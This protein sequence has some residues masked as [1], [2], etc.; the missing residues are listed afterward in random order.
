MEQQFEDTSES[1]EQSEGFA[2]EDLFEADDAPQAPA[3]VRIRLNGKT[4]EVPEDVAD[5]IQAREAD[6][7]RQISKMGQE[8]G[9]YRRQ[10]EPEPK[11]EVSPQDE[12]MEFFTSPSQAVAKRLK[13]AEERAYRR[14]QEDLQREKSRER[15]WG[16]FYSDNS[17]LKDHQD[18]VEF[19]V[20]KNYEDLKDLDQAN[21]HKEIASRVNQFLGRKPA[22]TTRSLN[23][24]QVVTERSSQPAPQGRR[25]SAP[26]AS[27]PQGRPKLVGISA[28]LAA[29]AEKRRKA[30]YNIKD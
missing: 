23:D 30:Q 9:S 6:Y 17:D 19:V 18:V 3:L 20:Q 24:R 7:Q 11:P 1:L 28:A 14:L 4:I 27:Q 26:E 21:A 22:T 25:Q 13:E 10:S 2:P 12:D 8:L 16:K 29:E 5:A 15:W